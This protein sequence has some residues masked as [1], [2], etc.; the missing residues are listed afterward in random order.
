MGDFFVL[1]ARPFGDV[2]PPFAWRELLDQI[3]FVARFS[4]VP[5]IVLSIP[6]TV[7]IV[8]TL[9]N[10][11]AGGRRGRSVRAGAR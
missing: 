3:W 10:R 9:N 6:Y 5:T 7:L 4:I 1:A 11:A 2:S 8:F